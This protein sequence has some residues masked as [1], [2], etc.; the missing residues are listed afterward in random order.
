MTALKL[1]LGCWRRQLPGFVHVDLC[2]L[3]HI[4]HRTSVDDLGM[5]A[6]GSAELIY[7]SHVL[8]YFDAVQA[9]KVLAEWRR[10]LQPG[11]TL[12][13]AVPDFDALLEVY[14]T[15]GRLE[16]ILGPLYG[17]M[18]VAGAD[19]V[20]YHRTVYNLPRLRAVLEDAGF[21]NVRR[22]DWRETIHKDFD[23]HSQAYWPHMDKENGLLVSLNVEA[24]KA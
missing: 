8:E 5:I 9:P 11:G 4:D 22:Y 16:T 6:D 1:H 21:T 15:S 20:I 12:R 19:Q 3:P 13:L 2:D 17:R 14:R 23:D 7:A 24:D 18:E 10:V